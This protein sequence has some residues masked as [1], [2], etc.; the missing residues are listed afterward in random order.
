[1]ADYDD[2]Y[3]REANARTYDTTIDEGLRSYMM[4]VYNY[5]ALGVAFTA[6]VALYMAG[7]P[8]L[9][10]TVAMGPMK[11]VLF[12]GL[13]GMGFLAPRLIFSG[14][15]LMA[16]ACFWGYAAMWG[17]F[18]SPMIAFYMG[19][20]PSLIVRAFLIT[21][22][23]FAGTSLYGYTTKKD[24]SGWGNFIVMASIGLLVAILANYFIFASTMA[25]L[26][27]SCLVVLVFSAA[28]AWET[29]AIKELYY[30]GDGEAVVQS[31]AI[32]GAFT[33]YGSFMV[34][35]IHILNILGIM[36]E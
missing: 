27:I 21:S 34:L 10:M 25:S 30:G 20:D 6:V 29:Q 28:T 36:R 16:Q 32:F 31:K 23:T 19:L 18:I 5:M 12:I 7:N 14:N 8:E 22:V 3:L 17:L 24:L 15:A 33:L 4:K 2:Q 13:I 1:M 9:M 11:W 35:F 26:I